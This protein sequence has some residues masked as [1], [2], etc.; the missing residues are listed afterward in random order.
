MLKLLSCLLWHI[1]NAMH[2]E[3][4]FRGIFSKKLTLLLKM[5]QRSEG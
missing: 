1:L 4:N 3:D 2:F 5:A